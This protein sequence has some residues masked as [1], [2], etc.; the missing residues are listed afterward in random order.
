VTTIGEQH[1]LG[2][3]DVPAQ[4]TR[5]ATGSSRTA[6]KKPNVTRHAEFAHLSLAELREYRLTLTEEE[7]R[8]SY[9]RRVI[10]ARLDL[11]R[12]YTGGGTR[13]DNLRDVLS[14]M[15]T[16]S[17]RG[18]LATFVGDIDMPALPNLALLWSRDPEPGGTERNQG[19]ELE[20][21]AAET[22]L[23]AYRQILHDQLAAATEDLIARYREQPA[24]CLVALPTQPRPRTSRG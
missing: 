4:P 2:T 21:A 6:A 22:Q 14:G 17:S 9:W 8:V 11:V 16:W 7:G 20:L 24:L 15:N 18:A 1:A 23:S 13:N 12:S 5:G 19:L 3:G 10:Q